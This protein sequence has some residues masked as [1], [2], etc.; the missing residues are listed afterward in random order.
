M[1]LPEVAKKCATVFEVNMTFQEF[2][3][4]YSE[5]LSAAGVSSTGTVPDRVA[6]IKA[7]TNLSSNDVVVGQNKA[8]V[9]FNVYPNPNLYFL[10][11]H[12]P[13]GIPQV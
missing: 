3:D 6:K 5:Q 4:R 2:F 1:G 9:A 12:D 10:G 13:H 7:A 8:S 11:V